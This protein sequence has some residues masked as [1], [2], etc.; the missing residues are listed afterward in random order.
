M[1]VS[2]FEHANSVNEKIIKTVVYAAI[3]NLVIST[4]LKDS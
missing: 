1:C 2:F 4:L 3:L